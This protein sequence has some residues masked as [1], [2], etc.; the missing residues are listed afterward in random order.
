VTLGG[1]PSRALAKLRRSAAVRAGTRSGRGVVLLY[2]RVA[3]PGD[4]PWRMAVTPER[5]ERHMELLR[6]EFRPL[7]LAELVEAARR[8]RIP[9]GAVAVTFDDGYAD[10]LGAALPSLERAQVPATVF[11]ATAFVGASRPFW[12]D[13]L[14]ALFLGAGRVSGS[15]GLSFAER[16]SAYED[17]SESL[18]GLPPRQAERELERLRERAGLGGPVPTGDT[19]P[20]TVEELM[21][22]A[23]SPLIE[24]GA[25]T[26][27][28]P[29]LALLPSDVVR[30]EV[31]GSRRDLADW[32]GEPP[33]SFS[34]PFGM[35]GPRARGAVRRAGFALG[36]GT[37]PMA[38][39]WVGDRF[40]LGR[41]WVEDESP[42]W[43]E[44][45]LRGMAA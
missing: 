42:E 6:S 16:L 30:S 34:Y 26:R 5:F 21:R 38:V 10:N 15:E 13:E 29:N 43:L 20:L 24:I 41:L 18:R 25:H 40:E 17:A 36:A 27:S 3:Q 45:H 33:A 37:H 28:H 2:H 22:L 11:V 4:D 32:L 23:S 7:P 44:L 19:R 35:H 8:R 1:L 12:W 9:D 31:E 39:T 14:G